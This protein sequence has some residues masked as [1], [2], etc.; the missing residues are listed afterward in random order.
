MKP[1]TCNYCAS[2]DVPTD[3]ACIRM[4]DWCCDNGIDVVLM[5]RGRLWAWRVRRVLRRMRE[6]RQAY[7]DAGKDGAGILRFTKVI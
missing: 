1:I 7:E 6:V 2:T 5:G 4:C 3:L